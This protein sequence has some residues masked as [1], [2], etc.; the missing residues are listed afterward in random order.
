VPFLVK[1]IWR[2]DGSRPRGGYQALETEPELVI[3]ERIEIQYS[4]IKRQLPPLT[5]KETVDLA[6]IFCFLWFTANWTVNAAL[7]YTSVASATILSSMS[8]LFTLAIGRLFLVETLTAAKLIAV[9]TSFGGV[10]LVSLSDSSSPTSPFDSPHE[11]PFLG[12]ILALISAVVYALYVILLKV[13][14]HTE[15]R[16]D[17]Q[18]FFGFVGLFNI[19]TCWV[20]G[21]VLHVS[22][23]ETFEL[24]TTRA[25][26][27]AIIINMV[28]TLTSDYLYV[29]AMLK[30]TPLVV[31]I[32]LSLTIP[33][34][35]LGDSLL[36]RSTRG[37]VLV[38]ALLVIASFLVVGL[39]D[40]AAQSKEEDD[41]LVEEVLNYH[42]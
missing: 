28:I 15:S 36:G 38:G 35:V 7:N 42:S 11:K 19:L 2:M 23:I 10:L 17:M 39:D 33:L 41:P 32:G 24:P 20:I 40:A 37:L 1:R 16:I 8:G 13:R 6:F 18:L 30:T 9:L 21:V 5:V 3:S 14:I 4:T 27:S 12:D 34:A 26:I 31:T 22:G 25:A 29:L